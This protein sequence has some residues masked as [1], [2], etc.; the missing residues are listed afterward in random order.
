MSRCCTGGSSC[1]TPTLGRRGRRSRPPRQVG[2]RRSGGAPRAPPARARRRRSATGD[3]SAAGAQRIF[4]T[5]SARRCT[6]TPRGLPA[7]RHLRARH[8]VARV[9]RV[10]PRRRRRPAGARRRRGAALREPRTTIGGVNLVVGFRPELWAA[11]APA[12]APDGVDRLR[13]S[14]SSGPTA[15]PCPRPSTTSCCGSPG[16]P[17]TSSSTRSTRG[18][19]R[20]RRTSPTLADEIVGWPYHHD[21]DLTG[22]IDGT[23]N[24]T[25]VE[26]TDVARRPAGAPGEGGSV[27]LLQQWEHDAV[28][29]GGARRSRP[30]AA[31][32]RTQGRQRR[33]RP[34]RPADLARRPHRPGRPSATSSGATS[35]TAP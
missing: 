13:R 7:A 34:D 8:L 20:A 25:L 29:V 31:I 11:V 18:D 17:T 12:A 19:R 27:L 4:L 1:A 23:E 2:V 21:R 15:S 9:P 10:R 26:A 32:G 35:P 33:A 6:V 28:G 30:G 5:P 24:P 16:A 22:F 14:R 3:V